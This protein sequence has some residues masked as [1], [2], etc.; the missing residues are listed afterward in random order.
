VVDATNNRVG[1]GTASPGSI[2]TVNDPGTGLQFTN[3][4]SGN[5]NLGLLAGVGGADAYVYQRANANL[6]VGTNNAERMRLTSAGVLELT[7]GQ[8][9]FPAT[10]VASADANT[11]DDYEEGTWTPGLS[12]SGISSIVYNSRTGFYTK[13]GNIVTVRFQLRMTSFSGGSGEFTITGLPFA[14]SNPNGDHTGVSTF[15]YENVPIGSTEQLITVIDHNTAVIRLLVS[16]NNTGWA[17]YTPLS[18]ASF[19]ASF[20]YGV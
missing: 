10:Q 18:S 4:A 8:I 19:Y 2:V 16:R 5:F 6:I 20:S 12:A 9:K 14:A 15:A 3:A 11:L 13:I 7:Q 1:V 17:A